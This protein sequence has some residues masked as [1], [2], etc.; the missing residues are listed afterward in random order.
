MVTGLLSILVYFKTTGQV[1]CPAIFINSKKT[2]QIT[3]IN[4]K[5]R[6]YDYSSAAVGPPKV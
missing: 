2:I 1:A 6:N 3:V 5:F 4:S